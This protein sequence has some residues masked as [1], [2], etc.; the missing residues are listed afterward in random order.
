MLEEGIRQENILMQRSIE[1]RYL[2]QGSSL[3]IA[4]P[5]GM[6]DRG[7]LSE[8]E[9]R[10]HENHEQYYGFSKQEES[11]EI[12]NARVACFGIISKPELLKEERGESDPARALKG[13]RGVYMRGESVETKIYD[14]E[15]LHPG[16]QV[17]GPAIIEQ[18]DSTTFLFP[19]NCAVVDEYNN[20]VVDVWGDQ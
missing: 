11:T 9:N 5:P 4:V 16:A 7:R 3:E 1:M 17:D 10:F 19:E 12:M 8:I 2:G 20:I 6:L 14:R 18:G 15:L 13:V